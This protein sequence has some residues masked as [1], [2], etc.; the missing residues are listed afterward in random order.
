MA[1]QDHSGSVVY[2]IAAY[3]GLIKIGVAKDV[4]ARLRALQTG[5]GVAL[6]LLAT[7]P[8][9]Y[10]LERH[11]HQ[12]FASRRRHGEWFARHPSLMA[13]IGRLKKLDLPPYESRAVEQAKA[14]LRN[15][16][17]AAVERRNR[18]TGAA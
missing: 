18:S 12:R 9:S 10:A 11:Y 1:R 7:V 14:K 6:T 2:F 5:S 13:E 15:E 3:R 16:W 4:Q 8:G 17:S